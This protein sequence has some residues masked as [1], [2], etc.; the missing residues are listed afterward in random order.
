MDSNW[1]VDEKRLNP[2]DPHPV[3]EIQEKVN[4][5]VTAQIE[6]WFAF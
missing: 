4:L 2:I 6:D 3:L 5:T 1:T